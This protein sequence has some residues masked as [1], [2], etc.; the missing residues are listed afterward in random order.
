MFTMRITFYTLVLLAVC[1]IMT[2][3][4]IYAQE[5][6][7]KAPDMEVRPAPALQ[8]TRV[9]VP[10]R[11]AMDKQQPEMMQQRPGMQSQTERM[12]MMMERM[13]VTPDMTVQGK[14]AM[15]VN[16]YMNGP[17]ALIGRAE[18]LG[19]SDAQKSD[20]VTIMQ[21]ARENAM[22]VLT[23]EQKNKLGPTSD[24]M[25]SMDSVCEKIM[26][27]IDEKT[28]RK[29]SGKMMMGPMMMSLMEDAEEAQT[30][31]PEQPAESAPK[32]P[33]QQPDTLKEPKK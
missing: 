19:L 27:A 8:P 5:K 1:V 32:D 28:G 9:P 26:K 22:K 23:A 24:E 33:S 21:Q 6:D 31:Q 29:D 25:M 4:L 11:V 16:F 2:T 30:Q 10:P 20:L 14:K 17:G 3:G 15:K 7:T 13:G 18:E 12:K